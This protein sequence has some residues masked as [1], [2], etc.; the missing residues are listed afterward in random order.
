MNSTNGFSV[1]ATKEI[2]NV[3][4]NN[5]R[6]FVLIRQ[7]SPQLS[8]NSTSGSVT[9]TGNVVNSANSNQR[10]IS[11]RFNNISASTSSGDITTLTGTFTNLAY[12]AN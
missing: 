2:A 6:T 12:D 1:N 10:L 5:F 8:Y 7:Q 11:G 3:D 4:S 9:I